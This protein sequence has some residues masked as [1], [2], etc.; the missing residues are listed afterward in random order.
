MIEDLKVFHKIYEFLKWIHALLNRFPKSEKYTMAQ[1]IENTALN[2]LEG[3]IQSNNDFDKTAS[4]K[5]TIVE[6][7]KLRIFFRMSKDLQFI[8]FEQYENGARQIDEIGRMLGGMLKKFGRIEDSA[9]KRDNACDSIKIPVL[10]EHQS[11][12][13]ELTPELNKSIE[14][15]PDNSEVKLNTLSNGQVLI[16]DK[17]TSPGYIESKNSFSSSVVNTL[18]SHC[19]LKCSSLDQIGILSSIASAKNGTSLL[20]GINFSAFDIENCEGAINSINSGNL[21]TSDKN[22]SFE[23]FDFEQIKSQYL[24]NSS[25]SSFGANNS[26][27]Y[28]DNNFLVKEL[29]LNKEN[30]TLVST[31]NFIFDNSYLYFFQIS[32]LNF[33]PKLI[34]SSSVNSDFSKSLS[35]FSNNSNCFILLL[36]DSLA[37]SDQFS[38]AN[39]S[40]FCLNS[41]GSDKVIFAIFNYSQNICVLCVYKDLY[42][43]QENFIVFKENFAKLEKT[44]KL[45]KSSKDF[46]GDQKTSESFLTFSGEPFENSLNNKKMVNYSKSSKEDWVELNFDGRAVNRG[47]NWN[48]GANAGLFYANL[49]NAPSNTNSNIGFRCC[50]S[51]LSQ[52]LCFYGNEEQCNRTTSIQIQ[53]YNEL[54]IKFKA[55]ASSRMK[56]LLIENCKCFFLFVIYMKTYKNLFEKVTSLENLYLAYQKARKGKN[57]RS[58]VLYF[59]Y[60]LEKELL[61]IQRELINQTYKVGEYRD[62]IIFEPKKREISALPFKDRVVQ[63]AIYN[64]IEPIF[65]K[66]FIFDSYACRKRKGTYVGIKRLEFFLRKN[67]NLY[68]L[69]SDIK[70]YFSSINHEILKKI[71]RKKIN[72]KKLLNLIDKIIDSKNSEEGIPIGNLTSQLFANIFLNELDKFVKHGLRIKYYIRYMDDFVILDDE[73]EKLN[74]YRIKISEFLQS[75]D[76]KMHEKKCIIFPCKNGVD[77]L[78][79]VV[80]KNY[81]RARKSTV[82]R[83]LK[84]IREKIRKY[85]KRI[86]DFEK[87][88]ES[89]NSWEAY[90]NHGN[91]HLLKKSLNEKFKNV[92]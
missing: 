86:I 89:I 31:I 17:E 65:E 92:F 38:Q 4:L 80:F 46:R 43:F 1:K 64:I 8:S 57:K 51:S 71:I 32:S 83:G 2:V 12:N 26:K 3:I 40:I 59:T 82:K 90:M 78:G 61:I 19:F 29:D 30:T 28:P 33:L 20:C 52:T 9:L 25:I 69:K 13:K 10:N 7:D 23:T 49:N 91:T 36:K 81:K 79:Y 6:L 74:E 66:I 24:I 72:D 21:F 50:N 55:F 77:F 14:N 68:A 54:N 34:H 75:L 85:E 63:H 18:I 53:A 73:K 15:N 60:N 84:N 37:I 62:F 42:S 27:L 39:L 16:Y 22:F 87:L 45:R 11:Q 58:E 48:N 47:G 70:K 44:A 41:S 76:L 88:I 56:L 67:K 5:K 35:S